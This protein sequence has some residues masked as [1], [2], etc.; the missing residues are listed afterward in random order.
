MTSIEKYF[1]NMNENVI[2][3]FYSINMGTKNSSNNRYY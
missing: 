3:G 2:C 1:S